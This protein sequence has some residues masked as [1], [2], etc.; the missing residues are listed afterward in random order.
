M[1]SPLGSGASGSRSPDEAVPPAFRLGDITQTKLNMKNTPNPRSRHTGSAKRAALALAVACAAAASHAQ[2]E[3]SDGEIFTLSP[4]TVSS[5][6]D[7]GYRATNTLAGTRLRGSL[8]DVASPISVFTDQML[9]DVA[10]SNFQEAM[11]YSVNVENEDEYAPDDT[12]GESVASTTQN[13]VRGIGAGSTTRGFFK[14]SFRTDAYNTNRLTVASG[15]SAILFG[16][17]SPAGI[18]DASPATALLTERAGSI[19]FRVDSESGYRGT[20]DVNVPIVQD[21][22]AIRVAGLQQKTRTF[23]DPEYDDEQRVFVAAGIKPFENTD[24]KLS[25]EDIK[26]S[27]VRARTTLMEDRITDWIALGQPLYD[28]TNDMWTFDQGATWESRSDLSS[29]RNSSGI[30]NNDRVF[31]AEGNLGSD[32]TQ[33]RVWQGTGVSYD[34]N[35]PYPKSFSDDSILSSST[36]YYGAGDKTELDGSIATAV[37]EQKLADNLYLEFAYNREEYHRDQQDPLRA[38]L[39]TVQAD[40]N[41]YLP[42]PVDS[43]GNA[44]TSGSPELNPNAGRYFIESQHLAWKQDITLETLR[45][46]ASYSFDFG[47]KTDSLGWLGRYDFATMWQ[48]ETKDEFKFK[49]FLRSTDEYW[50]D[51]SLGGSNNIRTRYYMDL[52][53]LGGDPDGVPFP[54]SFPSAPWPTMAGNGSPPQ[55]STIDVTGKLFVAQGHL[56]DDSLVLTFGYREDTQDVTNKRFTTTQ[57]ATTHEWTHTPNDEI[58]ASQSGITRNLGAVYHTPL[59]WLSLTYSH[60]NAFNPQGDFMDWFGDPLPPGSGESDDFGVSLSLLD[61]KLQLR[62]TRF[63]S[64]SIDTVEYDWYY[65]EPKWSV[66]GA[67]DASWSM[68]TLYAPRLAEETGDDSYLA[69]I[70]NIEEYP[71]FDWDR[72]RAT[73]DYKAEGYEMEL[74]Y[75]PSEQWDFRLTASQNQATNLRIVPYLQEYI[76]SRWETWE[77]Y[78]GYPAWGQWNAEM[79]EWDEDWA[80]NPNSTGYQLL[81]SAA[82]MP[83]VDSYAA[84]EG[85]RTTRGREW[86]VNLIG[87]HRF[88]GA[89]KGLSMGGGVRYRSADTIGYEGKAN[90]RDTND[91]GLLIEDIDRPIKGDDIFLTDAWIGYERPIAIGETDATW[92][93]QL[94]VRNLTGGDE[95][96]PT[97]V[98]TTG[99]P[100]SY[101]RTSPR[102]FI[103]SNTISF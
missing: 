58:S 64:T 60:S 102:S 57:D 33:A 87:N 95:I 76:E 78:F 56:L 35:D 45:A 15:P 72:I 62:L 30:G 5:D 13:R 103:L 96:V 77:K 39:A 88:T 41:W 17:G 4:F 10:A 94:N 12:E 93:I 44:L 52:P 11:L 63:E 16:I 3:E 8:K 55:D 34:I 69:H 37:F 1:S 101:A 46:T 48:K 40:V 21:R 20:V 85:T 47:E 97:S 19:G 74:F 90:P 32:E 75:Q 68:V 25:Y 73:R 53:N 59:E 28:F 86:R 43:S 22:F 89:L 83:R 67:M 23:R 79:P 6:S 38:G 81:Y 31:I 18:I 54:M 36:N 80:T 26:D 92:S 49:Q 65:E 100:S 27:R 9:E 82:A 84:Q 29:W 50:I 7:Q 99:V 70:N 51:G 42:W 14:T 24:I 61:N 98:Y 66:V 91:L 71:G 2:T